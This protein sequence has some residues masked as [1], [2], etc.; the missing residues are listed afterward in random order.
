MPVC[1]QDKLNV[2][3]YLR[4][5]CKHNLCG[6]YYCKFTEQLISSSQLPTGL[7]KISM[8]F[9]KMFVDTVM[10]TFVNMLAHTFADTFVNTFVD[11]FAKSSLLMLCRPRCGHECL[12]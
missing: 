7:K 9:T 8:V 4:F 11:T 3:M 6:A 5:G 12:D 1:L 2:A 10:K